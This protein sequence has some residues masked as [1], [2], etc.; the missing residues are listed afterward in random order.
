MRWGSL[1]GLGLPS[2]GGFLQDGNT[3]VGSK[4]PGNAVGREEHSR[5]GEVGGDKLEMTSFS[6][7]MES[8]C[9]QQE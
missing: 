6:W 9:G 3:W 2:R 8:K 4:C 7:R 5:E 1:A